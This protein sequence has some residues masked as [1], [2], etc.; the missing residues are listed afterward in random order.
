M[1]AIIP[2]DG[3]LET[4]I[5]TLLRFHRRLLGRPPGRLPRGW[6]LTP[7]RRDRLLRMIRAFDLKQGGASY[8][9]VAIALGNAE[10]AALSATE[11][12]IS[13]SRSWTI[14]LVH[15]ARAMVNGGYRRLLSL[16]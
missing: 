2:L 10:A 14:R 12:K 1:A 9:A 16:R 4:R 8:R 7:H 6:K 11:W 5:A 15:A 13:A 3:D